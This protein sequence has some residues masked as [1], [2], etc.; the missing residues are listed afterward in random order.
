[1]NIEQIRLRAT[2]T[3]D[4]IINVLYNVDDLPKDKTTLIITLKC[5]A[6][7]AAHVAVTL[8]SLVRQLENRKQVTCRRK[9]KILLTTSAE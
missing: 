6:Q 3:L 7:L 2:N 5:Y 1:M 4:R 8:D 9:R